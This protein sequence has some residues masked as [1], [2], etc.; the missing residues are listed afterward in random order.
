MPPGQL[1]VRISHRF[2][3]LNTGG[4]NFFGLDQSNIHLS[5]EYGIFKWLMV[6]SEGDLLKKLLTDLQN[7]QC[8]DNQQA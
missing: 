7:S 2:G 1:D 4:Y 5:L 8:S 6:G 3:T